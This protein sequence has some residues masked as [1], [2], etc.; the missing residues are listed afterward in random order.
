MVIWTAQHHASVVE[1]FFKSGDSVI[2][3]Q[4]I[5]RRECN[6]SCHG[7]VPSSN[8]IKLILVPY[9]S[10]TMWPDLIQQEQQ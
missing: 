7:A 6:V 10:N 2:T 4:C 9:G 3:A 5:F 1:A 8:T